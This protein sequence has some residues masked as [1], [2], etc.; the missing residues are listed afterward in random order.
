MNLKKKKRDYFVFRKHLTLIII[1]VIFLFIILAGIYIFLSKE[2]VCGDGAKYDSCSDRKPYFCEQ[3]TLIEKASICG[4]F[5]NLTIDGDF[6]V[7]EYQTEM[8]NIK[9]KLTCL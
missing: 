6:C 1:F 2:S 3:G 7:S 4:C 9:L 5:E 8:K